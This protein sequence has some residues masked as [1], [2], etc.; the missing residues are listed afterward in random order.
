MLEEKAGCNLKQRVENM[1]MRA[2]TNGMCKS[3][4]DKIN[5]LDVIGEDKRLKEIYI[6]IVNKM[7][8]KHK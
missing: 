1:K 6:N 5:P 2:L 7:Y 4:V 3:K 8:L